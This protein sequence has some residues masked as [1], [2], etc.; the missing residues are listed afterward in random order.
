MKGVEH[1][2]FHMAGPTEVLQA[3]TRFAAKGYRT[4]WGPGR[5]LL[6]SNWFWYFNSPFGSVAVHHNL[7]RQ[8]GE[9][10]IYA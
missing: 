10:P 6:G 4:F 9:V 2:T 5:H 1:F 7:E 8:K 3:G